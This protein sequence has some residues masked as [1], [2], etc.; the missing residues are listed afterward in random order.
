MAG[1]ITFSENRLEISG[2]SVNRGA[3]YAPCEHT[4]NGNRCINCIAATEFYSQRSCYG[5]VSAGLEFVIS[6]SLTHVI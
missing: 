6:S 2:Q 5:T 3:F 1:V 4:V